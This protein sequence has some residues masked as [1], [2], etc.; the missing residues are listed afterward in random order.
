[1]VFA[2]N[3]HAIIKGKSKGEKHDYRF[4]VGEIWEKQNKEKEFPQRG[5]G[6][7]GTE[8][9]R[10]FAVRPV[11]VREAAGP[12]HINANIRSLCCTN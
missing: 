10:C 12:F 8:G 1:M 3:K 2:H 6:L 7:E 11:C 4:H 9:L 5:G